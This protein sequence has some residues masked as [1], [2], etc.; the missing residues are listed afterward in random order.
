MKLE[1]PNTGSWEVLAENGPTAQYVI[2]R[3]DDAAAPRVVLIDNG[4]GPFGDLPA[5]AVRVAA[6]RVV[7]AAIESQ[8]PP[9]HLP[10]GEYHH[11]SFTAFFAVPDRFGAYRWI[12]E[13]DKTPASRDTCFWKITTSEDPTQLQEY[14]PDSERYKKAIDG[15]TK[16]AATVARR[17]SSIPPAPTT[18]ALD[19]SVDLDAVSFRAV[20][21]YRNYSM[22]LDELTEKQREFVEHDTEH[23]VKLRGPAGSGKTLALEMKLLRELYAAR[24]S[25]K[26]PRI[27]FATHSWSMAEQV[28]DALRALDESGDLGNIEV[29]PLVAVAQARMPTERLGGFGLLGEDSLTGK[30][31]QLD[32]ISDGVARLKMGDWLLYRSRVTPAFRDRMEA[33]NGTAENRSLVWDLMNEFASVLSANGILPGVNAERRY[34]GVLRSGWMMP[35]DNDVEKRVVLQLYTSY[36]GALKGAGLLTTDQLIYD[37]HSFLETFAWNIARA[38]EGYDYIFV[39]E[40]HLFGE[41]ERL[42]LQYLTPSADQYPRLF[43]ALDPRQS[44]TEVYAGYAGTVPRSADSGEADRALG[45]TDQVDLS[46]VHRFS[47]EILGL[48]RHLH[49][50]Y[51]ALEMGPDWQLDLSAVSSYAATGERPTVARHDNAREEAAAVAAEARTLA[52]TT[53]GRVAIVLLD[54]MQL[55]VFE[56]AAGNIGLNVSVI[57][58]RNDVDQLR[59]AKKSVVLSAAEYV[60]GLQFNTVVCAGFVDG[61]LG[62]A[63]RGYQLR[64]FLS[65]LYLAL[66]RAETTVRIHVNQENGGVPKVIE[67]AMASG[68]A[69][70]ATAENE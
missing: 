40:L 14:R 52:S 16:A 18:E 57:R 33:A 41:Q 42:V 21:Q 30:R 5:E 46:A 25:G 62:G 36:V 39:D 65:L 59:Y 66:S 11:G 68:R 22:W 13:T 58:G 6:Q 15:W 38:K 69:A 31:L 9:L 8:R 54:P 29:L 35:L 48:V 49:M 55:D 27:L 4:N 23:A 45:K 19:H 3:E 12:M 63:G 43:M 32:K 64:R 50:S 61:G 53:N 7:R 28:D 34:F 44:P 51:P 26:S 24:A 20:T 60:A 1:V 56:A 47:P 70:W 17:F 67:S 37:Y 10:W 2:H